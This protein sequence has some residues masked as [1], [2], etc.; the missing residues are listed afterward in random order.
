V[1]ALAM[2]VAYRFA[3]EQRYDPPPMIE[4]RLGTM[5]D[6]VPAPVVLAA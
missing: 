5:I 4:F 3:V 6:D 1:R 2:G